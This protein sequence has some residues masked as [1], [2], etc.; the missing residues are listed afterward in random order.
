MPKLQKLGWT[1]VS[2]RLRCG[3]CD[4]KEK[5]V[6]LGKNR[7]SETVAA[8]PNEPTRAQKRDI[9]DLLD[10][11]YDVDAECY[12]RGDTDE[13]VAD[14]LNVMPGWVASIREEFFGSA[15]DNQDMSDLKEGLDEL[16]KRVVE[17]EARFE[18]AL[19]SLV[20][21]KADASSMQDRLSAIKGAVGSRTLTKAGIK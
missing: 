12:R 1:Y 18:T 4:A 21:L 10:E 8:K 14:V 19:K 11:V 2:K 9:M 7:V 20:E 3:V 17:L 16:L 6:S 13:T 15:G 5:V